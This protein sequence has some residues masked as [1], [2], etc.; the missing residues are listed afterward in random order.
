LKCEEPGPQPDSGSIK[1]LRFPWT[2][3]GGQREP[4]GGGW[5]G[6]SKKNLKKRVFSY[7]GKLEADSMGHNKFP[8]DVVSCTCGVLGHIG[9]I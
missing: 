4:R 5:E 2:R 9:R 3:K 8:V 1:I 7:V 6:F